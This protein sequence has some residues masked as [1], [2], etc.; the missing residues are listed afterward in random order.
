MHWNSSL[1]QTKVGEHRE[2]NVIWISFPYQKELIDLLKEHTTAR[3]SASQKV[4]MYLTIDI[5]EPFS[6]T[7]EPLVGKM[8]FSKIKAVNR[9]AFELFQEHLKL[10]GYSR[11]TLRTY[12]VEFAQLLYVLKRFSSR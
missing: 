11:N 5:I 10:K 2:K 3:W 12:A 7:E 4:G 6:I 8:V 9:P 1:Y